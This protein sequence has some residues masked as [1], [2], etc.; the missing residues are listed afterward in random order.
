LLSNQ[1]FVYSHINSLRGNTVAFGLH[2]RR[3]NNRVATSCNQ[4]Q[5]TV[6]PLPRLN[7]R[8]RDFIQRNKDLLKMRSKK[9]SSPAVVGKYKLLSPMSSP[10]HRAPITIRH[11]C[12]SSDSELMR[13]VPL[14]TSA[15]HQMIRFVEDV[16]ISD[17]PVARQPMTSDLNELLGHNRFYANRQRAPHQLNIGSKQLQAAHNNSV[18]S[19]GEV[20]KRARAKS[21]PVKRRCHGSRKKTRSAGSGFWMKSQK[22]EA[23]DSK[24]PFVISAMSLEL[25][26]TSTR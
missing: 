2:Q 16:S 12:S 4:S 19:L 8:S 9:T 13:P 24:K 1:R 18:T 17:P 3:S 25:P 14:M 7:N 11:P 22:A 20:M 10:E 5:P 6:M 21:D 15:F 26:L 23:G